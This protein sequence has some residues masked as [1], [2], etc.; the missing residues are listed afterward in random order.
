PRGSPRG[1]HAARQR[2]GRR[3]VPPRPG[4]AARRDA[5]A[6]R[7]ANAEGARRP[8]GKRGRIGRAGKLGETRGSGRPSSGARAGGRVAISRPINK[9]SPPRAPATGRPGDLEVALSDPTVG[10]GRV[11]QSRLKGGAEMFSRLTSF[12]DSLLDEFWRLHQE[13]DEM[14]GDGLSS[15]G[16]IRSAPRGTFPAVNVI[17][18]PAEVQ[19]YLFAPGVDPKKLDVSVQRGLLTVSGERNIPVHDEA[20]YYR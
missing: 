20:A 19:V 10:S 7:P 17:Q 16:G 4:G 6:A 11:F 1:H 14:L 3:G 5:P 9:L 13:M 2:H 12:Q 15:A 18:T 8:G